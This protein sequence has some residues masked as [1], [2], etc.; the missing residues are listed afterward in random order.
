MYTIYSCL[1]LQNNVAVQSR[2]VTSGDRVHHDRVAIGRVATYPG[3]MADPE[4]PAPSTSE[5]PA[6]AQTEKPAD[7]LVTTLWTSMLFA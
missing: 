7:A 4:I 3:T 6:V 1:P 5:A 2:V